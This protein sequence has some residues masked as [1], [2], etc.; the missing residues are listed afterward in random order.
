M[1]GGR[2]I[3]DHLQQTDVFRPTIKLVIPNQETIGLAAQLAVFFLIDFFEQRA[4]VELD[5]LFQVFEQL[6]L[7]HVQD[8][9]FQAFARFRLMHQI[10]QASPGPF[11][12]LELRSMH[13]LVQLTGQL[14]VDL[15]DPEFDVRLHIF[16]DHLARLDDLFEELADVVLVPFPLLIVEGSG[17]V[18]DLV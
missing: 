16:G 11:Q 6:A 2:H 10:V 14:L 15:R 1:R 5:R 12:L 7:L 4:L 8:P 9:D 3:R 13:D 17:A 18:Q